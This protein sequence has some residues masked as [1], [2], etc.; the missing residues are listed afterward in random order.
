MKIRQEV[1]I[2]FFI[3]LAIVILIWGLN[4]LKGINI[5]SAKDKYYAIY[6]RIEGLQENA[7]VLLKGFKIGIVGNIY[8]ENDNKE[9]IFV[10]IMIDRDFRLPLNTMAIIFSSDLMGSKSIKLMPSNSDK[11]HEV[12]DTLISLVEADLTEQVSVQMLPLKSKAEDLMKEMQEA[13]EVVRL[14]FNERTRDNLIKSIESIKS[15]INNL[16]NTSYAI[17]SVLNVEKDNLSDIISNIESI[18]KA[19]R[20]NN[21]EISLAIQ[22][23]S[24][25]SDS[26]ARSNLTATINN[27]NSAFAEINE[28]TRKINSGEGSAGALVNNDTLYYNLDKTVKDLDILIKDINKNPGKYINISVFGAGE[29]KKKD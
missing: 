21:Q 3:L 11:F 6:D 10:E 9:D 7:P 26:I 15:T 1:K 25:I 24:A 14:L 5:F 22:N 4:Y 16:N 19:I 17:D 28:I 27:I 20:E 29:N 12:G 2:G 13:L 23:I 8:F 18:T